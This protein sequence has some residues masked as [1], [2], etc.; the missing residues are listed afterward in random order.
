MYTYKKK[1]PITITKSS[2]KFPSVLP[3]V[4]LI[5]TTYRQSD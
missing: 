4:G 1:L 5:A 2:V 3:E